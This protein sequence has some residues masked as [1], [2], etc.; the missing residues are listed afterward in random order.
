MLWPRVGSAERPPCRRDL[1]R[2]QG[3]RRCFTPTPSPPPSPFA[4]PRE[5]TQQQTLRN[6]SEPARGPLLTAA[7]SEQ[8]LPTAGAPELSLLQT[9]LAPE[10]SQVQSSAHHFLSPPPT[11]TGQDP[12]PK[13]GLPG[14][15]PSELPT[16]TRT[17]THAH[18]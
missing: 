17:R 11:A 1:H 15:L 14:P 7:L 13:L 16:H 6:V 4:K 18:R 10:V 9:S 3:P 8:A 5:P 12:N 2:C